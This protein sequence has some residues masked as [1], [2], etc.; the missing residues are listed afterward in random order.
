MAM[1]YALCLYLSLSLSPYITYTLSSI[2]LPLESVYHFSSVAKSV[3]N[4]LITS[5]PTKSLHFINHLWACTSTSYIHVHPWT[6]YNN[7]VNYL[8]GMGPTVYSNSTKGRPGKIL[9]DWDTHELNTCWTSVYTSP[10]V[11]WWNAL[12]TDRMNMKG[13]VV[14]LTTDSFSTSPS[15]VTSNG[16][17]PYGLKKGRNTIT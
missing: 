3:E 14:T 5:L 7:Y 11:E 1:A 12:V 4:R 13:M 9:T 6:V 8:I 15:S 16:F 2:S 10:C 17:V